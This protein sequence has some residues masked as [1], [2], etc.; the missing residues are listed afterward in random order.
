MSE[1]KESDYRVQLERKYQNEIIKIFTEQLH[2][3]Y[4]GNLS[5]G[6]DSTVNSKNEKN[7]NILIEEVKKFLNSPDSERKYTQNEIDQHQLHRYYLN[8]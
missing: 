8:N 1:G 3:T 2:Y 4:L 6:K 7:S 5:Y